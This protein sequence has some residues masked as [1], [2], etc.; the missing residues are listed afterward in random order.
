MDNFHIRQGPWLDDLV[1]NDDRDVTR[2][3][4]GIE[5]SGTMLTCHEDIWTGTVNQEILVP[6]SVLAEWF[7]GAWWRLM[8]EPKPRHTDPFPDPDWR[9][10]HEIA[11]AGG[12]CVWPFVAF[13][14]DLNAMWVYADM[15]PDAGQQSVRY[16]RTL[17]RPALVSL[18]T[19]QEEV[20]R[21]V[22]RVVEHLESRGC[23][24]ELPQAWK[25]LQDEIAHS[26]Y[27][28]WRKIE[29][30]LGY[31]PGEAPDEEIEKAMDLEKRTGAA[32]S[33]EILPAFGRGGVDRIQNIIDSP[34]LETH[35]E[36]MFDEAISAERHDTAPWD[37]A[38]KHAREIRKKIGNTSNPL[39]T[40]TLADW[41]N[42]S[43]ERFNAD[44]SDYPKAPASIGVAEDGGC[45]TLHLQKRLPSSRRY[46]VARFVGDLAFCGGNVA[47]WLAVTDLSTYRQQYQRA[48]AAELLFPTEAVR[49]YQDDFREGEFEQAAE[50]YQV[51]SLLVE[52]QYYN[53]IPV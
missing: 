13:A 37:A 6:N 5:V 30:R 24:S 40:R 51:S 53:Q 17:D 39:A 44:S 32:C 31:Y 7:V 27:S 48:F 8:Y 10:S 41:L 4:L 18:Q 26:G 35:P 47:E 43:E 22:N 14:T 28:A 50:R 19:F 52:R 16:T 46:E 21:F 34:G 33:A 36:G 42:F 23:Q 20:E 29:A 12:G 15:L 45:L 1:G 9:M 38:Y 49:E 25:F 11:G 2:A 3:R